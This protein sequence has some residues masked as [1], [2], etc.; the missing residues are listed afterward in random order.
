MRIDPSRIA[1]DHLFGIHFGS[2]MA[3]SRRYRIGQCEVFGRCGV[4]QFDRH[5]KST[6]LCLI[7]RFAHAIGFELAA[8]AYPFANG[9]TKHLQAAYQAVCM[10]A[11]P[12]V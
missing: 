2:G 9:F 4:C 3:V 12:P 10:D 5:F 11:L 7:D 6:E 8:T 1:F